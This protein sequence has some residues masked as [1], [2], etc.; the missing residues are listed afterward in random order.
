MIKE[1][2][3]PVPNV[4]V[5]QDA[6]DDITTHLE[7]WDQANW[8]LNPHLNPTW[9]RKVVAMPVSCGTSFCLAGNVIDRSKDWAMVSRDGGR[10]ADYVVPVTQLEKEVERLQAA[11]AANGGWWNVED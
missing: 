4:A 8:A 7:K 10:T 5:I 11:Q 3:M 1:R 2:A 9:G 6:L